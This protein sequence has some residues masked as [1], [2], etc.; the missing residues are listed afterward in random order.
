MM[1]LWELGCVLNRPDPSALPDP[2]ARIK[3]Q[4]P[5]PDKLLSVSCSS[6]G[7]RLRVRFAVLEP[8]T[9]VATFL[10]FSRNSTPPRRETTGKLFQC[11]LWIGREGMGPRHDV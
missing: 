3:P 7:S 2:T 10:L 4:V 6:Q 11:A 1:F 8:V 9:T 5:P